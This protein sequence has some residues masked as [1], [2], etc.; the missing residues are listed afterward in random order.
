MH[1]KM[2]VITLII[3]ILK[4]VPS[5]AN[6]LRLV[7]REYDKSVANKNDETYQKADADVDN[8]INSIRNSWMP[9]DDKTK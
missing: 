9:Y 2:S 4:Q 8:A 3:T 1:L 7:L 6:L 5:L